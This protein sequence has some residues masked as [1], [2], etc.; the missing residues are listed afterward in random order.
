MN[1]IERKTQKFEIK[2][3]TITPVSVTN[4]DTL[5]PYTDF[6]YDE[7]LEKVHIID[8]QKIA[9]AI[10]L[11]DKVNDSNLMDE[12]IQ[13]I[14]NSFQNNRS[15][16]DLKKFLERHDKLNLNAEDYS[17]ISLIPNGIQLKDRQ[18]IK[19]IVK[20]ARGAFIPGSSLKGAIKMTLLYGWFKNV[21]QGKKAFQQII[22]E[23]KNTFE[24]CRRDIEYL[25]GLAQKKRSSYDDRRKIKDIKRNLKK[26]HIRNMNR[27]IQRQIDNFLANKSRYFP[28]DFNLLKV[29]DSNTF[30]TQS[31]TFQLT[32][33]IHYNKG[34]TL[35]PIPVEAIAVDASSSGRIKIHKEGW[36]H[37]DLSYLN[38]EK[39]IIALFKRINNFHRDNVGLEL[40]IL[41]ETPWRKRANGKDR[42]VFDNYYKFLEDQFHRI[43]NVLPHEAYLCVGFGKSFYYNSIG[44]LVYDWKDDSPKHDYSLYQKYC[45]LHFLGNDGQQEFPLTRT[46]THTGLPMGWIKLVWIR[47]EK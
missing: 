11:A 23:I 46:V 3:E 43:K 33:R 40:D 18:E 8:K 39:S 7:Q 2:I 15:E 16:F 42:Q 35:M 36:R 38:N 17:A 28:M 22:R 4:G 9:S 24:K 41:D 30:S 6:V 29:D 12:Y 26:G 37:D 27:N 45:K 20:D 21:K 32:Q 10:L 13:L 25:D 1:K 31:N 19:C 14:Q 34:C 44:I 5:S 47:N